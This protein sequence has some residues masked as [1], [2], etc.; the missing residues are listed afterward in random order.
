MKHIILFITSM[1]YCYSKIT[2]YVKPRMAFIA[3]FIAAFTFLSVQSYA[4]E[5]LQIRAAS[6]E[7]GDELV[8]KEEY[9]NALGQYESIWGAWQIIMRIDAKNGHVNHEVQENLLRLT[10]K[11]AKMLANLRAPPLL[12][13]RQGA[14]FSAHKGASFV[15]LARDVRDYQ[16]AAEQF[17]NALHSAPWVSD[18]HYNLAVC[19]KNAGQLEPALFSLQLA[20]ILAKDKRD[21]IAL[22]AEIEAMSEIKNRQLS[23]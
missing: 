5:P 10:N 2:R 15:K 22:R 11:M 19:Q 3:T 23:R 20:E 8:V 17:E 13:D 12:S 16:A 1:G 14:M 21:I 18:L 4:V 7:W 6:E 9:R